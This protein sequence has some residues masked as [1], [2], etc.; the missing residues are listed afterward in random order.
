MVEILESSRWSCK[1]R[2]LEVLEADPTVE[3]VRLSVISSEEES[4]AIREKLTKGKRVRVKSRN[5]LSRM[6]VRRVVAIHPA[7][8]PGYNHVRSIF[9]G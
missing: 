3:R 1:A 2:I 9:D 8:P 7:A 6:V 5:L 4:K